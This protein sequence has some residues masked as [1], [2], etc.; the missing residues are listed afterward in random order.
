MK[1]VIEVDED[2]YCDLTKI[3]GVIVANWWCRKDLEEILE[4][5]ISD[6]EFAR[7]KEKIEDNMPSQI[8]E[9]QIILK[10]EA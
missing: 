6:E 2:G 3:P 8:D 10:E 7:L 4:R 1:V 9:L 5:K